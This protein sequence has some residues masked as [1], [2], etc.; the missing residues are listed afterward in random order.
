[1]VNDEMNDRLIKLP[2][3][4]EIKEAVFSIHADKSPRPDGFSAS[5]FHTN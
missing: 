1:M 2:T 3:A 4:E 5:F